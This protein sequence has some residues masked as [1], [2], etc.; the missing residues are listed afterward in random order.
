[1]EVFDLGATTL[2]EGVKTIGEIMRTEYKRW[3]EESTLRKSEFKE[4]NK[5]LRITINNCIVSMERAK[6]QF[7]T[8]CIFNAKILANS[9]SDTAS[10][11]T[12]VSEEIRGI[13]P[14]KVSDE[15]RR[16]GRAFSKWQTELNVFKMKSI[17]EGMSDN[18]ALNEDQKWRTYSPK[19]MLD[20]L[21]EFES[22]LE[23]LM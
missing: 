5:K 7:E 20:T 9:V 11:L 8:N 14:E 1:M 6:L 2:K 17:N 10:I 18:T 21:T 12:N 22:N 3:R 13:L 15:T 19:E 23:E 16:L 4:A